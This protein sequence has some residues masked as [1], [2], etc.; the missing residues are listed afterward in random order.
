[1][2]TKK[3]DKPG[4][5]IAKTGIPALKLGDLVKIRHSGFRRGRIVELRGPLGPNGAQ[6]YRVIIRRKPTP[7]YIEVRE[8]QLV[9]IPPEA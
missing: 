6:I 5:D 9:A 1:M 4:K 7:A 8:D 3:T 2:A